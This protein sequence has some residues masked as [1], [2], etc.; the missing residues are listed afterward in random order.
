M[1]SSALGHLKGIVAELSAVKD[2]HC[3]SMRLDGCHEQTQARPLPHD[4][5]VQLQRR[6]P[7]ARVSAGLAGQGDGLARAA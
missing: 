2:S 1:T 3:E 7:Q 5:L 6:A 4:E